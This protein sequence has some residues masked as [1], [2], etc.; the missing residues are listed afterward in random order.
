[1]SVR[2]RTVVFL[3]LLILVSLALGACKRERPATTTTTTTPAARGTVPVATAGSTGVQGAATAGAERRRG[4][5]QPR[6]RRS[7][8]SPALLRRPAAGTGQ[9]FAY[10]VVAGDTLATIAARFGT[11]PEAISQLNSLVDPNALTLGQKLQIP[12][13]ATAAQGGAAASGGAASSGDR[14]RDRLHLLHRQVRRHAGR[15]RQAL[16]HHRAGDRPPEQP[17]Q[18]RQ[19]QSRPGPDPPRRRQHGWRSC[20]RCPGGCLRP[21]PLRIRA[22]AETRSCPSPGVSA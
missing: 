14:R 6:R 2:P 5:P 18:P 16:R 3:S 11:T 4:D 15:H 13:S 20:P 9:S 8:S 21:D 19:P 7:R 12:G 10:T 17:G 22:E 1:M